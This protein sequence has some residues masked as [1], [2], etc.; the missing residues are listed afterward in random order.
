MWLTVGRFD[1]R[2]QELGHLFVLEMDVLVDTA[3][4][5]VQAQGFVDEEFDRYVGVTTG[6]DLR[7]GSRGRFGDEGLQK[8]TPLCICGWAEHHFDQATGDDAP[9]R[10][11]GGQQDVE[12]IVLAVGPIESDTLQEAFQGREVGGLVSGCGFGLHPEEVDPPGDFEGGGVGV[13]RCIHFEEHGEYGLHGHDLH[14]QIQI[15]AVIGRGFAKV[16]RGDFPCYGGNLVPASTI[17]TCHLTDRLDSM[18]PELPAINCVA[19]GEPV[20]DLEGSD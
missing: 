14:D 2:G 5:W 12:W 3:S 20:V 10:F 19:R 9:E 7:E 11:V 17:G 18:A 15:A 16:C 6:C 13:C 8:R 4:W 1:I